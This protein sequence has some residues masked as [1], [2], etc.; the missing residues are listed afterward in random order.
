MFFFISKL[1][2]H[3]T[4]PSNFILLVG[5]AGVLLLIFR[6]RKAGITFCVISIL[7][8]IAGGLTPVPA[9]AIAALENRFPVPQIT[10]P[11]TGIILL[12]GAI[13]TEVS[14]TRNVPSMTSAGDRIIEFAELARKYPQAKLFLSGGADYEDDTVHISE[15]AFTKDVLVQLGIPAE[16]ISMEE[17]SRN[18][19]ENATESF[20]VLKPQTNETWL[21]VTSASHMPRAVGCFRAA[22]FRNL[23]PYPVDFRTPAGNWRMMIPYKVSDSLSFLDL[24][25]HEWI[26]LLAYWLTGRTSAFFPAPSTTAASG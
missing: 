2:G 4:T 17:K 24:A 25:G 26:G 15:S 21:L 8:G 5:I 7:L 14:G 23:I 3:F 22:G 10:S 19:A 16:R 6:R 13:D 20:K 18:T 11:P 12:G 9:L 1:A